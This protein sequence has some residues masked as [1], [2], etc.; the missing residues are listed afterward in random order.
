MLQQL[1]Y[2]L[3]F[4]DS[5]RRLTHHYFL[6]CLC[7]LS[8]L[9]FLHCPQYLDYHQL[10]LCLHYQ[11]SL[12]TQHYRFFQAKLKELYR[13]HHQ[14]LPLC[15]HYQPCQPLPGC[16][17]YPVIPVRHLRWLHL[18]HRHSLAMC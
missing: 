5:Q 3:G 10:P 15:Q 4:R 11:V 14:M 17:H 18:R 8:F 12:L 2:C 9:G 7:R 13:Q 16:L 6:E 1:H